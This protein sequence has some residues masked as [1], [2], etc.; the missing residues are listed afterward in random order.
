L[1][2]SS[3]ALL[4]P[5]KER[6]RSKAGVCC[7]GWRVEEVEEVKEVAS[8]VLELDDEHYV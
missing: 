4:N 3:T 5:A 8:D 7:V 1:F 6:W 2:G